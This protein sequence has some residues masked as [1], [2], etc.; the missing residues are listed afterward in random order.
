MNS[1][2]LGKID[3]MKYLYAEEAPMKMWS[4]N[5]SRK[6]ACKRSNFEA[7]LRLLHKM[8][9]STLNWRKWDGIF[10]LFS[11]RF[12]NFVGS[13]ES[14]GKQSW[15]E[16]QQQEEKLCL[17]LQHCLGTQQG[18]FGGERSTCSPPESISELPE[19]VDFWAV[20]KTASE[21]GKTEINGKAETWVENSSYLVWLPI[22]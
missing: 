12:F 17:W 19:N 1:R 7:Y 9:V 6:L 14:G 13:A 2:S 5:S 15:T 21:S 22:Y 4:N 18:S 10:Q 11:T 8:T 20:F 3:A 16:K